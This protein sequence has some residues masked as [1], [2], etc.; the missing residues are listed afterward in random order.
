MSLLLNILNTS[1]ASVGQFSGVKATLKILSH[2]LKDVSLS[3]SK[4]CVILWRP[5]FQT[6]ETKRRFHFASIQNKVYLS[7]F[8]QGFSRISLIHFQLKNPYKMNRKTVFI[9]FINC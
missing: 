1:F 8:H 4:T 2:F 7:I 9:L 6:L 5:L 3:Y